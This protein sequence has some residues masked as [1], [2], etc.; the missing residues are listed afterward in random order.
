METKN[1]IFKEHLSSWLKARND[2]KQRAEITAHVVFV[3]H[4]HPKSVPRTFKRLQLR[5][6]AHQDRRGRPVIYG[7]DVTAALKE[8]WGIADESCG[9]LLHPMLGDYVTILKRDGLWSWGD[10]TTVQLLAMSERTVKRRLTEFLKVRRKRRGLS[11]TSPSVL[12]HII[13]IFKG[14]WHNLPPGNGQIDTV[15]HCGESLAGSFVWTVNYTDTATY[16]I[17]PRAQWNK[18]QQS[19]ITSLGAICNLVPFPVAGLHPDSGGE[20]I[21]WAAKD[22]CDRRNI[23]LSRSEPYK[24][25]DNMYVEER[26][27]HVVRRYLGWQRLDCA[28]VVTAVNELYDVLALYLNHWKAVRRMTSK[29]RVNARYVRRYEPR[30]KTPYQRVLEHPTIS[31]E[32]KERLRAKHDTLNPL[33]LKR[34]IDTLKK[35]IYEIQKAARNRS[36]AS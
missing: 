24:K 5:D 23:N 14:P 34:K 7:Q 30:A 11:G 1:N 21:N 10:T 18:G 35:K 27:G 9:E 15:A 25:N 6:S 26:N 28:E 3:T 17:A 4:C 31:F 33:L 19:T 8:L 36:V 12:K 20:F 13:P 29:E 22:W 16:W 2:R 32:V